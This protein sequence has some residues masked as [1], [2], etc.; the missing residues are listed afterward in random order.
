MVAHMHPGNG[1]PLQGP[2][3]EYKDTAVDFQYQFIGE[4]HL[5]TLLSTY[6]DEKQN[7][8][9]SVI[10]GFAANPS[11]TLKTFKIVGEYNYQRMIGGS[12]AYFNTT[13]SVD[14]MLYAQGAVGG[15]LNNSPDSSGTVMEV[16][17]LPWLNT[18]LQLQYVRYDKFNG[19]STNYDGA[20]RNAADNDTVYLLAWLNF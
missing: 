12:L 20:G 14:T 16:N 1:T 6:I 5:F 13:G 7:L 2:T 9:A 18:K 8:D 10:D 19:S 17:Y 15:S 4:D 3:D 11:D